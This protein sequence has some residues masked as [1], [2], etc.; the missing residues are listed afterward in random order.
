[1]SE[2]GDSGVSASPCNR[3]KFVRSV[4]GLIAFGMLFPGGV[5]AATPDED[6][7]VDDIVGDFD[8]STD[9]DADPGALKVAADDG[10]VVEIKDPNLKLCVEWAFE[11]SEDTPITKGDLRGLTSLDCGSAGIM[12][13]TPLVY[14][15]NVETLNLHTNRID[16]LSALAGLTKLKELVLRRNLLSDLTPLAEL[17]N[18]THLDLSSSFTGITDVSALAGLS[19]LEV[20]DLGNGHRENKI[21]DVTALAGL[22][23]LR[24]LNLTSNAVSDLTPLAGLA[25]LTDLGVA[26]QSFGLPDVV[27]G[28]PFTLPLVT[29]IDGSTVPVSIATGDGKIGDNGTITW[30]MLRGGEASLE[31]SQSFMLGEGEWTFSGTMTQKVHAPPVLDGDRP[32]LRSGNLYQSRSNLS[33]GLFDSEVRYGRADDEVFFGDWNG[34]GI[35]G[36]AVRR[37]TEFYFKNII[38]PG[39]ADWTV[40]YGRI[41]DD[42]LVG[43]WNGDGRDTLTVRRGNRY[44]V[45]NVIGSGAAERE[46]SYGR[47]DDEVLVGDWN[48]DRLDTLAV[49]RGNTYFLKD[50]ISSGVADRVVAFGNPDDEVLIGQWNS[51]RHT[52]SPMIRHGNEFSVFLAFEDATPALT[53]TLGSGQEAAYAAKLR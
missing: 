49:R 26:G 43:D 46:A 6:A 45:K 53:F 29:S 32:V 42:V 31:W 13:I 47:P 40:N 33:A 35:D 30:D 20:L 36:I 48:G 3:K 38:G 44:F 7:P 2:R 11:V 4:A 23:N 16:D 17:T 9:V 19:N 25:D 39:A 1:M 22:T 34:D 24:W 5:A 27:S 10:D 52:D 21:S 41:G 14:A 51:N 28:E 8:K 37:G 50:E 12:D 15:T 18:L